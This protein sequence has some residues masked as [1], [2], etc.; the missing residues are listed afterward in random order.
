MNKLSS[1]SQLKP[2]LILDF[3][4]Q[5]RKTKQ[6][7]AND[8][9]DFFFYLFFDVLSNTCFESQARPICKVCDRRIFGVVRNFF[10]PP[11]SIVASL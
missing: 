7:G 11:A 1:C 9:I 4:A 8:P 2:I 6:V 10:E 3:L 5:Q